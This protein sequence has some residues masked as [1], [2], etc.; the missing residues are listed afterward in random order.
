MSISHRGIPQIA[1]ALWSRNPSLLWLFSSNATH[2]FFYSRKFWIN[3]TPWTYIP[4]LLVSHAPNLSTGLCRA[5]QNCSNPS[6]RCS[7]LSPRKGVLPSEIL[8]PWSPTTP[9]LSLAPHS[10]VAFSLTY[11]LLRFLPESSLFGGLS[12]GKMFPRNIQNYPPVSQHQSPES[13]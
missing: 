9:R 2:P 1:Q 7:P 4:V 5:N 3:N 13:R 10:S 6:F 11:L 8:F 12:P